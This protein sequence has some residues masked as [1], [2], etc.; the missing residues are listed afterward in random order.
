MLGLRVS[1]AP[2]RSLV[3][4]HSAEAKTT[5]IWHA[6]TRTNVGVLASEGTAAAIFGSPPRLALAVPEN[7]VEVVRLPSGEEACWSLGMFLVANMVFSADGEY[8]ARDGSPVAPDGRVELRRHAV[9]VINATSGAIVARLEELAEFRVRAFEGNG[10]SLVFEKDGLCMTL[11]VATQE[12][13]RADTTVGPEPKTLAVGEELN[14]PAISD[15]VQQRGLKTSTISGDGRRL[16]VLHDRH[17]FSLWDVREGKET[18]NSST[19]G[20]PGPVV[21]STQGEL[22]AIGDERGNVIVCAAR[23]AVIAWFKHAEPILRMLFS[24]DSRFLAVASVDTAFRLWP[25][26][27][28]ALESQIQMPLAL[29]RNDWSAYMGDE[30]YPSPTTCMSDPP[31]SA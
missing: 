24:P 30:P 3:A 12:V 7:A 5:T 4:I 22:V 25:V 6:P 17:M 15:A 26:S 19:V 20:E 27:L 1:F 28:D 18:L 23:G 14:A 31:P 9:E 8:L 2:A 11:N 29:D 10:P 13:R 16:C 21:F